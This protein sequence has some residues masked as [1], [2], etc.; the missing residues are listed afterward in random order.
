MVIKS[1]NKN[2]KEFRNYKKQTDT[3]E[4]K[5]RSRHTLETYIECDVKEKKTY[6]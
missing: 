5:I 3:T 4:S 1:G 6:P 2:I